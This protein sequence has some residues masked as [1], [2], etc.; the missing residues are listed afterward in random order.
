MGGAITGPRTST[1]NTYELHDGLSMLHGDHWIKVGA[2][3]RRHQL[4]LFQSIAP[5]AFFIFAS[6]FPTNDAFANLLLGSPVVF[7]QGLGDF[8]RYVRNWGSGFYYQDEWHARKRFTVNYGLR[9]EIIN[10]NTETRNRLNA[11]LPGVQSH[12]MPTAPVGLLFPGDPGIPRGIAPSYY[13]GFMPRV[14]FVWAPGN[15]DVWS[16]RASYGI[17]Y[18]PFANGMGVTSQGPVSSLPW[19]QFVQ[20]TPPTLDFGS[21][22][23]NVP[24]PAADTFVKPSTPFVIDTKARPSNAQDWNLSIQRELQRKYVLEV[25]YVGTKGT[26]L[27][28]NIDANPAVYGPGA[29]AQNADRRRIYANCPANGGACDYATVADLT[30]GQNSTYNAAQLSLTRQAAHGLAFNVSYW[31]SKTLDYLSSMNLQGASAKPL[32]GEKRPCPGSLRPQG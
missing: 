29:T 24:L 17:F 32:G 19:A 27:P 31:Y 25:R 16:I 13:K 3:F 18:D 30:Y 28:R 14:G 6:S 9:Y 12:V 20:I 15:Q 23:S 4:N 10:P 1:Q 26:H 11:F 21:P 22:Y 7:Y 5:N 8:T 2:E